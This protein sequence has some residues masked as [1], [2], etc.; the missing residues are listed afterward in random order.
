MPSIKE[1]SIDSPR[2]TILPL[3]E[4]LRPTVARDVKVPYRPASTYDCSELTFSKQ[5]AFGL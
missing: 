3:T 5:T 4:K 2:V 1:F